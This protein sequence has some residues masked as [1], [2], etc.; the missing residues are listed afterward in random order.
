LHTLK[1]QDFLCLCLTPLSFPLRSRIMICVE[2]MCCP[3]CPGEPPSLRLVTA[4]NLKGASARAKKNILQQGRADQLAAAAP[5]NMPR[6]S[7]APT[8]LCAGLPYEGTSA[9]AANHW[10]KALKRS[11][12]IS[13]L[14]LFDDP[15]P[16]H[17]ICAYGGTFSSSFCSG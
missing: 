14:F 3:R 2:R 13:E 5:S 6:K 8:E 12:A 9:A 11:T 7:Q 1:Q 4:V 16:C 15:G 10:A 17:P